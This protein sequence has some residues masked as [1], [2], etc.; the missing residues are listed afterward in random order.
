[1]P[2]LQSGVIGIGRNDEEWMQVGREDKGH[3]LRSISNDLADRW[4]LLLPRPLTPPKTA[5]LESI[6]PIP[7]GV[8]HGVWDRRLQRVKGSAL[9]LP[10]QE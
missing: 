7:H 10:F 4:N 8:W 6:C 5:P 3:S 9:A 1:M 2:L